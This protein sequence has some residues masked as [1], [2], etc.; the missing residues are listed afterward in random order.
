MNDWRP[1]DPEDV[2]D[3]LANV[4]TRA[5]AVVAVPGGRTPLPIFEALAHRDVRGTVWL[6]DDRIVPHDHAASN[7]GLLSRALGD[8]S[9]SLVPLEEG[10]SVPRFDLV[11]L[12]MGADGHVASIFPNA[13]DA[14]VAGRT[15]VRTRPDPLPPEA[16]FERLT[17]TIEA[18]ANTEAAILVIT[19]NDKRRVLEDALAGTRDLPISR[20]IKALSAPL[21]VYWSEE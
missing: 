21:T 20:Y 8:T 13:L 4:L 19:G 6:V 7:F 1:A 11:W 15:V 14:L 17:L 10:A 16:P 3:R 12:G 2:A 9:L 18:L 5:D